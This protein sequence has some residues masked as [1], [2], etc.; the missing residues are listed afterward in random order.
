[1]EYESQRLDKSIEPR[2]TSIV[3]H[4]LLRDNILP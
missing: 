1:M 2:I 4:V 3:P